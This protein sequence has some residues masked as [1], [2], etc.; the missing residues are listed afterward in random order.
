MVGARLPEIL[1]WSRFG[2]SN[3]GRQHFQREVTKNNKL[4]TTKK[5]NIKVAIAVDGENLKRI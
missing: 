1:G 5:M 4:K 2:P 3:L